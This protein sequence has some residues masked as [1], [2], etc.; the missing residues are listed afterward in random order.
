MVFYC[1]FGGHLTQKELKICNKIAL[2]KSLP[3]LLVYS[4]Y[5]TN[6]YT[7]VCLYIFYIIPFLMDN[8]NKLEYINIYFDQLYTDYYINK[9]SC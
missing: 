4:N 3:Y 8:Y 6:I 1:L 9:S 2:T 7:R 5:L